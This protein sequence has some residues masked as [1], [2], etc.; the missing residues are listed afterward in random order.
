M[1]N[2]A[3]VGVCNEFRPGRV[4]LDVCE[5]GAAR[6]IMVAPCCFTGGGGGTPPARD[7]YTETAG[8]L[9]A[10][11]DL[12]PGMLA[13]E[14]LYRPQY[15]NLD[16]SNLEAL[17]KGTPAGE[18]EETYTEMVH[19]PAT[20]RPGTS[21]ARLGFSG[22]G[23]RGV[24]GPGEE[25]TPA[26]D[27]P[28]LKTRKV[29]GAAQRGLLDILEND[30]LPAERRITNADR[31][32]EISSV[33]QLGPRATM[34][35]RNANPDQAALMEMLNQQARDE[36]SQGTH[37]D[38]GLA[39]EVAQ[40]VRAGQSARGFGLGL[41][42]LAQEGAF[43]GM[44]AEALRRAR[45]Q[46]ATGVVGLNQ[47]TSIDPFMAVLSRPS[48][49]LNASNAAV[50]QGFAVGNSLG[51][52]MFGSSVN[53]ND[54]YDSNFNAANARNIA[55]QNASAATTSAAIQGGAALAGTAAIA[56]IAL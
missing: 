29:Q 32:D 12:A 38:P 50:N 28:V 55:G 21:G 1:K 42:D 4:I 6:C 36:L 49:A 18:R 5:A 39:R 17:L 2:F 9:R 48:N 37:L 53:A 26:Y 25:L 33:E 31:E 41:S 20:Y 44:Q 54:V 43:T 51:P 40:S 24:G 56:A 46:F 27:R 47:A 22:Y 19:V 3:V 7:L 8:E 15:Q 30:L 34:A 16:L 45:Q 35:F 14:R 10:K 13:A 23:G 52:Q 11:L